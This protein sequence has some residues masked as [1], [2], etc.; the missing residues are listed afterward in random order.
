MVY[1]I[2]GPHP[3]T[4][5]NMIESLY[6][7]DSILVRAAIATNPNTPADII[8]KYAN[9]SIFGM[10][11]AI[12]DNPSITTALLQS[13]SKDINDYGQTTDIARKALRHLNRRS[14]I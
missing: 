2:C 13:L 7:D 1:F 14:N 3:N 8:Y 9:E 12:S 4:T 5:D 11:E 10:Q 6:K